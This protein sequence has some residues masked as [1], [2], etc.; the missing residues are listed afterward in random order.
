[1]SHYRF[2]NSGNMLGGWVRPSSADRGGELL[3]PGEA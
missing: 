2:R 1:V 3:P